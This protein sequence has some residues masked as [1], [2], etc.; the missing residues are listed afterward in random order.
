MRLLQQGL[1]N[2]AIAQEIGISVK[3]VENHL[4]RLY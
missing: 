4:T 1:D 2:Y 3:T